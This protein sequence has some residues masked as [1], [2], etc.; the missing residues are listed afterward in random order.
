MDFQAAQK[1]LSKYPCAVQPILGGSPI[2]SERRKY[3]TGALYT[4]KVLLGLPKNTY[5]LQIPQ[6]RDLLHKNVIV[7]GFFKYRI[8]SHIGI[9]L[10][11]QYLT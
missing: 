11:V 10:H 4:T 7:C 8:A 5:Q 2:P 1:Q 3:Y 9:F 6:L